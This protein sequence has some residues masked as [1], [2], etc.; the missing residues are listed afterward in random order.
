MIFATHAIAVAVL[1]LVC[2]GTGRAVMDALRLPRGDAA[3]L[4]AVVASGLGFGAMGMLF[5]AAGSAGALTR[6]VVIAILLVLAVPA[7]RYA[8][9]FPFGIAAV[10]F[11]GSLVTFVSALYPP[12]GFDATMY[13]LTYAR[14]FAESGSMVYAG[15][16]RFPV[17]P[18]LDEVVFA[19][20]L[21]VADDLT[22]QLTQWYCMVLTAAAVIAMSAERVRGALGAAIWLGVPLVY[23]LG[24][25][26]YVD[27][28]L[29]MAVTL[30]FAA[31]MQPGW[32][33]LVG[34]FAGM[35]AA[36]KYHGLFFVAFFAIAL[37]RNLPMYAAGVLVTAVPWYLRIWAWTG[38]P[39]FPYFAANDWG[40]TLEAS[41][42]FGAIVKG[43]ATL[44]QW[45]TNNIHNVRLWLFALIVPAAAGAFIDRRLRL[46]FTGAVLYALAVWNYDTRFLVVILP[47][48]AVCA[49]AVVPRAASVALA[50]C[51]LAGGIATNILFDLRH[52]EPIPRT[53][54]ARD[55][56]LEK[57]IVA[58]GALRAIERAGGA[59]R[60][61]YAIRCEDASYYWNGRYLGDWFG[62]YRYE[63]VSRPDALQDFGAEY[64]VV[65]GDY[66]RPLPEE[67]LELLY[68]RGRVRAYRVSSVD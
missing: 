27:C 9:E 59:G 25:E 38:N 39:L 68:A 56:F 43:G 14:L 47:L 16:T 53:A 37:R 24:S 11:A 22:A 54:A 28:G 63:F 15:T 65:C 30:A 23:F 50:A 7:V 46:A 21:L 45:I 42:R 4:R 61:V 44:K 3:L 29:A 51:V 10:L 19:A 26:A 55:A 12:T 52:L 35:A 33:A 20:A 36:T 64:L 6:P 49:A 5:F 32:A 13:H 17:F 40:L 57:R 62:P 58:Y 34:A 67:G 18:Q 41:R 2:H 66:G 1:A 48:L 31:W 60:T 8:R